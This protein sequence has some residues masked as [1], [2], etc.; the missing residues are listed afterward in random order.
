MDMFLGFKILG[1]GFIGLLTLTVFALSLVS[2]HKD[3]RA[4]QPVTGLF[5]LVLIILTLCILITLL[6]ASR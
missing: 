6:M 4:G 3:F 1:L 2:V 5:P